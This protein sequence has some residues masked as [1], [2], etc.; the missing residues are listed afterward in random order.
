MRHLVVAALCLAIVGCA[1]DEGQPTPESSAPPLPSASE[2]PEPSVSSPDLE[3]GRAPPELAG[4]WRRSFEGDTLLLTLDGNGYTVRS[5]MDA[6]AGR[7]DVDGDRITFSNSNR[8]PEGVGT[9]AWSIEENGR[10]RLTPIGEDTCG[11][12]RP[13]FLPRATWGRVDD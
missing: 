10:L 12:T 8:C 13:D 4:T 2:T 1:A 7:I 11:G 5:S 9:Y 6:G 3:S